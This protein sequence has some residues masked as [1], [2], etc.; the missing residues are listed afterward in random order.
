MKAPMLNLTLVRRELG[1]ECRRRRI[2][3]LALLITIGLA[4]SAAFAVSV[5]HSG[6]GQV[7][8]YPYYTARAS[9]PN[10][11]YDTLFTVTN[12]TTDTKVVRLRF[13]ESRNGREVAALNVYLRAYDSWTGAVTAIGGGAG[14]TTKDLSCVDPV[15][16]G[17]PLP[18]AFSNS[19]Y[20]GANADGEESSL[21]RTLEGYFEVF[22]LGVVKDA[23]V[24]NNIG[25]NAPFCAAVLSVPLDNA[26]AMGPPSGGLTGSA[27][28]VSVADGTMYS[29]DATAL[30]NFS[31][32]PLWSR[33]GGAS[34]TL[35]DVNPKVS[36]TFSDTDSQQATWDVAKGASPADPVSAVL[37]ADQLMNWFVL[38]SA[39]N[40]LTDWVVT[41]PTKP[42]YVSVGEPTSG[43]ARPP[44]ETNFAK[45][46]APDYFGQVECPTT[47]TAPFIADREGR[48]VG[49]GTFLCISPPPYIPPLTLPWTANV[50]TFN[51][52]NLLNAF[53]FANVQGSF[54]N[55]WARLS[56]YPYST[57]SIHR[58][59]STDSPPHTYYG[60][61]MIGFM[62]NDY[63]N[64]TLSV[65]GQPV[66][67]N[68]SATSPHKP[69][70]RAQ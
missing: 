16:S 2:L 56:P 21:T 8:L 59:T 24:L 15:G 13:R 36:L 31:A 12:T 29:Y 68:Y 27:N 22:D 4:S 52:G 42:F 14:L 62:A 53:S 30:A 20:S 19:Q 58:L 34:P 40:S 18:L 54:A 38:D 70:M 63:V 49:D 44:F 39:T 51:N 10:G 46:G 23:T 50:V 28:I 47:P 5:S 37:M 69:I 6:L 64:R 41:M 55:G 32:V 61:P 7:L 48:N 65:G 25:P 11:S 57:G 60:L 45:G 35:A 67:S 1:A 3:P 9:G 26:A 66:L 17:N 43:S 33:P